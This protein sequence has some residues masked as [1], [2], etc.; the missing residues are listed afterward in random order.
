MLLLWILIH[1][2]NHCCGGMFLKENLFGPPNSGN[3]H[4]TSSGLWNKLWEALQIVYFKQFFFFSHVPPHASPSCT[5][6]LGGFVWIIHVVCV[7]HPCRLSVSPFSLFID[8][9]WYFDVICLKKSQSANLNTRFMECNLFH[10]SLQISVI[11][12]AFSKLV[13]LVTESTMSQ[14]PSN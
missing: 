3:S 12:F 13:S 9:T 1:Y 7:N 11:T 5:R 10:C 4:E 6:V 8:L 2:G 14:R